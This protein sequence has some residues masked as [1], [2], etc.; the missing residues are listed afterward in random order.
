MTSPS[1]VSRLSRENVGSSTSH[2]STGLHGLLLGQLYF[3]IDMYK[4]YHV[5]EQYKYESEINSMGLYG[6]DS[7]G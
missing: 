6:L 3:L 1:S 5:A 4:L 7:S 2:N